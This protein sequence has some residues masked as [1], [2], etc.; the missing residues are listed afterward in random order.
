MLLSI[1]KMAFPFALI[2]V[3]ALVLDRIN[4]LLLGRL[5][6]LDDVAVY[7]VVSKVADFISLF[8]TSM[9]GAL[10]PA[11]SARINCDKPQCWSLYRNSI[12]GFA[13]AGFGIS[14]FVVI[15][16]QPI[17]I[18]VFGETYR[19]GSVALRFMGLT[20][21]VTM[22]SGPVGLLLLATGDLLYRVV[23]ICMVVLTANILLSLWLIPSY[24]YT[25]AAVATLMSIAVGFVGRL[26]I[27]KSYFGR[28]PD[29]P[30]LVWR[31]AVASI[32]TGLALIVLRHQYLLSVIF[33]GCCTYVAAL[34]FLGEFRQP[35]YAPAFNRL[36]MMLNR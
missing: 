27:S 11:L 29:Y 16:S 4:I 22:L 6:T 5:K 15:L 17:I 1:L 3:Y 2:M 19:A 13:I 33:L 14:V 25:G 34:H 21:L 18:F 32:I 20:F 28:L 9:I 30:A 23:A 24:S 35:Q 8:S 26:I 36:K 31:P 12:S 7:A 10:Y